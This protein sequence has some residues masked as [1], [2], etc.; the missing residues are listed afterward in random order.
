MFIFLFYMITFKYTLIIN[1]Y[2]NNSYYHTLSC[3][4]LSYT[5]E[6]LD[7]AGG[8]VS[9]KKMDTLMAVSPSTSHLEIVVVI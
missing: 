8:C 9:S 6:D 3:R 1:M 2:I 4:G 5:N 7:L